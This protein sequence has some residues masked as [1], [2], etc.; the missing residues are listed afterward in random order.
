MVASMR[1]LVALAVKQRL[2]ARSLRLAGQEAG[3]A[4]N[5]TAGPMIGGDQIGGDRGRY[6]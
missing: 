1:G 3:C 4:F 2:S 6:H 5:P